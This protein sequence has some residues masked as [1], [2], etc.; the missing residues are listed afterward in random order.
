MI[1]LDICSSEQT[2]TSK[3]WNHTARATRAIGSKSR[4]SATK[5]N[6]TCT[7]KSSRSQTQQQQT[8]SEEEKKIKYEINGNELIIFLKRQGCTWTNTFSSDWKWN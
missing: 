6:C 5:R 2:S 4:K 7:A 1:R 3:K 8:E